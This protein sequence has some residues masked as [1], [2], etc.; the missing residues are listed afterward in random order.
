MCQSR[1]LI[2][3]RRADSTTERIK[4]VLPGPTSWAFM[5]SSWVVNCKA[6]FQ[7]WYLE[8]FIPT[9]PCFT[10]N[11]CQEN[12]GGWGGGI[13]ALKKKWTWSLALSDSSENL[14]TSSKGLKGMVAK[15]WL[16]LRIAL[17][18]SLA[19]AD[20]LLVLIW[21]LVKAVFRVLCVR[22][23]SL[24]AQKLSGQNTLEP[25]SVCPYGVESNSN[26]NSIAVWFETQR[27][28]I[29]H[30]HWQFTVPV[31]VNFFTL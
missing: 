26:V 6:D 27:P 12:S 31:T 19:C 17:S 13:R 21:H 9:K 18:K 15:K 5:V 4:S 29:F 1:A 30:I 24:E 11:R 16:Q 10:G 22:L 25:P 3:G 8:L 2:C 20:I 28:H 7:L 23:H 14:M